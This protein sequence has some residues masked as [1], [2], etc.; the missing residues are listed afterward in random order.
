MGYKLSFLSPDSDASADATTTGASSFADSLI[1]PASLAS[2]AKALVDAGGAVNIAGAE[3][4]LNVT[5]QLIV[6]SRCKSRNF[7][8]SPILTADNPQYR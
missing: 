7:P 1:S 6:K 2:R 3:R 4:I 5:I 8:L